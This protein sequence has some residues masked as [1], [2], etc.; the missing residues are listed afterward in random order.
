MSNNCSKVYKTNNGLYF[1][2]SKTFNHSNPAMLQRE[3]KE[4]R[5]Q[6]D[7]WGLPALHGSGS[8]RSGQ[9]AV[10]V[11]EHT[12]SRK[13]RIPEG[14]A[15]ENHRQTLPFLLSRCVWRAHCARGFR[16]DKGKWSS[17]AGVL[18]ASLCVKVTV[19]RPWLK[20]GSVIG[21]GGNTT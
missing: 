4:P 15:P 7:Q 21:T 11:M 17:G 2:V 18:S 13:E 8:S 12:P 3:L 1:S 19:S 16:N 10:R 6:K 20:T 5:G 14:E 9:T